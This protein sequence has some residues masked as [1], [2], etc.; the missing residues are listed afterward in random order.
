[1][2]QNEASLLLRIKG[3]SAGAKTAVAETRAAMATLRTSVN[4]EMN[5]LRA[6]V[7][8]ANQSTKQL[9][10]GFQ[11]LS[12]G[13]TIIDGPL[14][15]VASRLR[16]MGT[17]ASEATQILNATGTQA[18]GTGASIAAIAGPIGIAI[19]ATAALAAGSFLLTKALF[20]LAVTAADFRGKMFDL[21]QQTGVA[22]ETLSA[23]E[24]VAKTTGGNI[25]SIAQ[26]LVIFQGKLEEAQ[27]SGSK[28]GKT[29]AELGVSTHNTE[30]AFRSALTQ[31]AKMPV[32]FEQTNTAAELFGRRGGKQ[33]LAILKEMGGDLDGA[34]TKFRALG[35]IISEEDARAADEFNDQLAILHFQFR[36][37]LGEE[38]IPA[39]LIALK[40]LSIFLKDNKAAIDTLGKAVGSFSSIIGTGLK[41]KLVE[42]QGQLALINGV[43]D[44]QAR[45]FDRIARSI[46]LIKATNFGLATV[47]AGSPFSGLEVGGEGGANLP[48][49]KSG[50]FRA[51][52]E[53]SKINAEKELELERSLREDLRL[54]FEKK[55]SDLES[56][57][58]KL[59]ILNDVHLASLQKQ[60]AAERVAVQAGFQRGEIDFAESEKRKADLNQRATEAQNK[61]DEEARRL[62]FEKQQALDKQEIEFRER[63]FAL[64]E[65]KRKGELDRLKVAVE[66]HAIDESELIT[67]QI[68]F[69]KAAQAE[70]IGIID[71]EINALS[72]STERKKELDAEK[73]KSEQEYTD[74]FKALTRERIDALNLEAAQ[75][76]P[77]A[78]GVGPVNPDDIARQAGAAAD[79]IAGMPPLGPATD[80]FTGLGNAISRTLGFGKEAGQI[81]GDV[82]ANAFGM[83]AQ[84]VG[85][86]VRA[87]VL[88]GKV[89]GG[90]RKFAAE[91]IAQ[92]AAMAAVQA[93]YQ[94]AQALAWTALNF[95]FPNPAYVKAAAAAYASAAVF[96]SIAG[97][98]AVAGRAVAG[99]SFAPQ[100]SGGTSGGGG[101]RGTSTTPATREVDRR[102]GSNFQA[103]GVKDVLEVRFI[104]ELGDLVETKWI[105]RYNGGGRLRD[106]VRDDG[107]H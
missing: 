8:N 105:E 26:S 88:F 14:G 92:I 107:Q 34:I 95:F 56:H 25:D 20:G 77:G 100:G 18:A 61:R 39:A 84:G 104:G 97:V 63:N 86:A 24:I 74:A 71:F 46:G 57:F 103:T 5:T 69:L 4:S 27:D 30:D 54:S 70:R 79:A 28:A 53:A 73:K 98:A 2:S 19:A 40:D 52:L 66:R 17:V 96:G 35:L 7:T 72:T 62:K 11:A 43:L 15:G 23:L 60:I 12:A 67:K 64:S 50:L 33:M 99:N 55:N 48:G 81:F 85:E 59:V 75:R 1:M 3:D 87:F 44:I 13:V 42:L 29:F 22:V 68:E 80:A 32:G 45:F 94:L 10:N 31:I 16:A 89:E 93:V 101:G 6:S 58:D 49:V 65:T 102:G 36:A 51:A 38:V 9:V 76:G 90:I 41:T 91:M 83:L 47:G 37:L 82:L 78:T 21:S 106:T